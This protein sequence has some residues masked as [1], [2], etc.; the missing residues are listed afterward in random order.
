M[1]FD[2]KM[3]LLEINQN[4]NENNLMIS[5]EH[6]HENIES[7]VKLLGLKNSREISITEVDES[8]YKTHLNDCKFKELTEKDKRLVRIGILRGKVL[9][10]WFAKWLLDAFATFSLFS[11]NQFM[12]KKK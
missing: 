7:F 5:P 11:M 2:E 9:E 3:Y 6:C 10:I 4:N 8:N 1:I 12:K